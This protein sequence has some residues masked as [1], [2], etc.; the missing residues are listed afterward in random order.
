MKSLK[1]LFLISYSLLGSCSIFAQTNSFLKKLEEIKIDDSNRD[2]AFKLVDSV[3]K[4]Y[5][6]LGDLNSF[7]KAQVIKGDYYLARNQFESAQIIASQIFDIDT[8]KLNEESAY[9]RHFYL[10]QYH[11]FSGD[12]K[13]SIKYY[14]SAKKMAITLDDTEK[15]TKSNL[16]LGVNNIF[17]ENY[18]D[19]YLNISMALEYFEQ[20]QD[21]AFIIYCLSSLGSIYSN[22]DLSHQA[23]KIYFKAIEIDTNFNAYSNLKSIYSNIGLVYSDILEKYDSSLYYFQK[24]SDYT[25]AGDLS[26]I[27]VIEANKGIVYSKMGQLDS[28]MFYLDKSLKNWNALSSNDYT[29]AGVLASKGQVLLAQKKNKAALDVLR[30]S[31]QISEANN[32][33]TFLINALDDLI[34]I[35]TINNDYR[36][37]F[38]RMKQRSEAIHKKSVEDQKIAVIQQD[39]KGQIAMGK[40]QNELL[41]TKNIHNEE[42]I[43][44]QKYLIISIIFMFVGI[45]VFSIIQFK[46]QKKIILLNKQLKSNNQILEE[47]KEQLNQSN[48]I[49]SRLLSVLGHDL[50]S[51]FNTLIGLLGILNEDWEVMSDKEKQEQIKSVQTSSLRTYQLLEDVLQFSKINLGIIKQETIKI[52][53][54]QLMTEASELIENEARKKEIH[55]STK[56]NINLNIDSNPFL[57][58]QIL[59]NFLTNAIK[60]TKRGGQISLNAQIVSSQ[61]RICVEDN[62]IGMPKENL[63]H[64]FTSDFNYNRLGTEKEKSTGLGLILVHEYAKLIN[65]KIEVESEVNKGSKFC[66]VMGL[67]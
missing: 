32:Y 24:A 13:E 47:Q 36:K 37:A 29:Q 54:L 27:A 1:I 45:I 33:Y 18:S 34:V 57:I 20:K 23:L 7:I 31:V 21:T 64:I 61:V 2:S 3:S 25:E 39:L 50:K 15:I 49:K 53:L 41:L 26:S 48:D 30:K 38:Y 67:N 6:Q 56:G 43:I 17:L 42:V 4:Q 22:I 35:D 52:N 66:I 51:P 55:I 60:F 63:E 65:A 58:K 40:Q 5:L 44:W 14:K 9:N 46:N 11:F 19:A 10:G 8:L 12:K 59:Q 28:A 16:Q 62:G